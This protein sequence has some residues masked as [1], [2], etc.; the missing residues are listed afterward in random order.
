MSSREATVSA[1]RADGPE[2]EGDLGGGDPVTMEVY[3][4]AG[5]D[6]PPL[7]GD[8]VAALNTDE[9]AEQLSAVA[10]ADELPKVAEPGEKRIYARG[11]DGELTA[12]LHI[13]GD[14]SV[15]LESTSG[16]TITMAADGSVAIDT[17]APIKLSGAT[18]SLD[19]G[20]PLGIFLQNLHAALTAWVPMNPIET[21]AA[22]LKAAL[23][24]WLAQTPPGP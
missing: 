17:S 1:Y 6:S 13:R 12:E 9:H 16:A 22:A 20:D 3:G 24:L 18:V 14:G 23:T 21:D 19:T 2:L 8:S 10:Y 5:D 15:T 7:P 4:P 11:P